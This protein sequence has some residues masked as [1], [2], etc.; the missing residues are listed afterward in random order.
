MATG[1][2]TDTGSE[3]EDD[4]DGDDGGPDEP[5]SESAILTLMEF[6]HLPRLTAIEILTHYNNRVE[7]AIAELIG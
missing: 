1:G 6:M 5:A 4:E 2:G 7:D 3:D